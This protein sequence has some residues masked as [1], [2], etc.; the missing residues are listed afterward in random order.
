MKVKVDKETCVS[1]GTCVDICPDIFEMDD[2]IAVTKM[3]TVSEGLQ[4]SCR[5]AAES[6][7]VEAIVIEE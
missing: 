5:E 1:C 3:D 4:E 2:D 7:P 6:C